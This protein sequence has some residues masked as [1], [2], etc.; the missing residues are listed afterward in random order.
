MCKRGILARLLAKGRAASQPDVSTEQIHIFFSNLQKIGENL[1]FCL[2][3]SPKGIIM[4]LSHP[5]RVNRI[6]L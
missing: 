1:T 5:E 6:R 3:K 4:G 2:D